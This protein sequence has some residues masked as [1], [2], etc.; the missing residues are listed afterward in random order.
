MAGNRRGFIGIF[1]PHTDDL[2]AEYE[3]DLELGKAETSSAAAVSANNSGTD[4]KETPKAES[5]WDDVFGDADV[6]A[7]HDPKPQQYS[8]SKS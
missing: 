7:Q 1:S 3:E 2:D 6:F 8:K 5:D 4:K